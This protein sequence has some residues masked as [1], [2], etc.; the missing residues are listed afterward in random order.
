MLLPFLFQA[1]NTKVM[2][3][4]PGQLVSVLLDTGSSELWVNPDCSTAPS[5][6]Q[7]KQCSLAGQYN[8]RNSRT[9]PTGP[10]GGRR[11]NYGDPS[12]P[13]TQTSAE[14]SYYSDAIT[15]SAG[16]V[17]NQ[18]FGVV[19]KSDG[20]STG[21]MGLAP[22]LSNGFT[23]D[24]PYSLLL[25]SLADQG[26]IQSRVFSLDLRHSSADNGALVYGGL[27]RGKFIGQLQ[28]VPLTNGA[29]GEPR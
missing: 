9:P 15:M 1:N 23:P 22:D 21:I 25:N 13:S 20:I 7:A 14:I 3:G 29:K 28:S 16:V 12:D 6:S 8:P 17:I 5:S 19:T 26:G 18:T 27:D 10:F 24:E 4:T 11:L 2:I